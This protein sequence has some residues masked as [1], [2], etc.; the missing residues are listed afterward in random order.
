[1]RYLVK[2]RCAVSDIEK[3]IAVYRE[4][5]DFICLFIDAD[6]NHR[7]TSAVLVIAHVSG[8]N[9]QQR[10]IS[11]IAQLLINPWV[12]SDKILIKLHSAY[13]IK[14]IFNNSQAGCNHTA[15]EQHNYTYY[16]DSSSQS[17]AFFLSSFFLAV[18]AAASTIAAASAVTSAGCRCSFF[19][20]PGDFVSFVS[21]S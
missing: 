16:N 12:D 13:V 3:S 4:H 11:V 7:V 20:L 8:I 18:P 9:S 10:Y 15:Q 14:C 6:N 5:L 19:I 1:M 17:S 2:S 21:A